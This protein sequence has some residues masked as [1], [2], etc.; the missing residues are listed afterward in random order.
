MKSVYR[1]TYSE[2]AKIVKTN[3]LIYIVVTEHDHN[4]TFRNQSSIAFLIRKITFLSLKILYFQI[5][6]EI[7]YR[8]LI[9][10]EKRID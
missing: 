3:Q 1:H 7:V 8:N 9:P 2:K 5:P 10:R 4:V 6:E